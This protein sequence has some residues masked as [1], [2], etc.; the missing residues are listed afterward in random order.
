MFDSLTL[1][2]PLPDVLHQGG[3][4]ILLELDFLVLNLEH[5][6]ERERHW[7]PKYLADSR[8][9]AIGCTNGFIIMLNVFY[10]LEM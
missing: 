9:F 3:G 6:R 2:R 1:F 4:F 7:L 5:Q 10:S 8:H